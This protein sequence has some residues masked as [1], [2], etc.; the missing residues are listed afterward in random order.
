M[1]GLNVLWVQTNVFTVTC[2]HHYGII[3]SS[4]TAVRILCVLITFFKLYSSIKK[5]FF[6]HSESPCLPFGSSLTLQNIEN[7]RI[8]Q[9]FHSVLLILELLQNPLPRHLLVTDLL[10]LCNV[11]KSVSRLAQHLQQDSWPLPQNSKNGWELPWLG[12]PTLAQE[13]LGTWFPSHCA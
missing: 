1:L 4:F 3:Q 9:F 11:S 5:I 13:N 12:H 8:F 6:A 7:Q 2:I 10:F